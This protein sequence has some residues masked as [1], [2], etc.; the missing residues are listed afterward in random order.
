MDEY[1]VQALQFGLMSP[2]T[3]SRMSV[4]E[5]RSTLIYD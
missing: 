5:I 3:V 2:E 1:R 4:A